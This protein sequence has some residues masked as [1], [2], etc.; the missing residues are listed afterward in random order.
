MAAVHDSPGEHQHTS[1][2]HCSLGLQCCSVCLCHCDQRQPIHRLPADWGNQ[3]RFAA[4]LD[5]PGG[6]CSHVWCFGWH[7]SLQVTDRLPEA[8]HVAVCYFAAQAPCDPPC[9]VHVP[10]KIADAVPGQGTCDSFADPLLAVC[11]H[12]ACQAL[13]LALHSSMLNNPTELLNRHVQV[14]MRLMPGVG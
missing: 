6:A 11:R 7:P 10:H 8:L 3:Q 4:D 14:S 1:S 9:M 13:S 12:I 5:F 2:K